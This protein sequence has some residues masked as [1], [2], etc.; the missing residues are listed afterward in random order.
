MTGG[1]CSCIAVST[2]AEAE[3]Y[4]D[5]G[6]D[7]ILYAYPIAGE[8]KVNPGSVPCARTARIAML[9]GRC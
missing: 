3:F 4:A 9:N 2:V 5:H 6:F 7:D 1:S 8:K